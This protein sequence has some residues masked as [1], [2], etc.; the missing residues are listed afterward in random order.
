MHPGEFAQMLRDDRSA[1]LDTKGRLYFVEELVEYAEGDATDTLASAQYPL[2]DTF[3]LHSKPGSNR[4]IYL[5]LDHDR[6][7]S[8]FVKSADGGAIKNPLKDLRVRQAR[9]RGVVG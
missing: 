6:D 4:V 8:P 7:D 1:W 3:K 9:V 5:H 2:A